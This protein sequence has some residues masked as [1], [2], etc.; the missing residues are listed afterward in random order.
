MGDLLRDGAAWL[1][2]TM[3]EHVA[4]TVTYQR[5]ADSVEVR[6]TIGKSE[7]E[8]AKEYGFRERW[9]S[10][11]FLISADALILSAVVVTP[12]E[13]D[14]IIETIADEDGVAAFIVTHEVLPPSADEPAWRYSDEHRLTLRLHTKQISREAAP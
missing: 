12:A 6:A 4:Q 7:G 3:R 14:R 9:E 2:A 10:K 8:T 11:D 5:G 13:N 1:N